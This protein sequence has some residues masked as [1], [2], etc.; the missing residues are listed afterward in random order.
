MANIDYLVLAHDALVLLERIDLITHKNTN[1]GGQ[2]GDGFSVVGNKL[3]HNNPQPPPSLAIFDTPQDFKVAETEGHL[4]GNSV[5]EFA[6]RIFL[7][8]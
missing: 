1:D 8:L 7:P 3:A 2:S 4:L 6:Y 5:E